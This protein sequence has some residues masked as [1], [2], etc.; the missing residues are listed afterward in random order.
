MN[1]YK[2]GTRVERTT[3]A[4]YDIG[5]LGTIVE[6]DTEKNR[7]RIFWDGDKRTW[8]TTAGVKETDKPANLDD[9]TP[10]QLKNLAKWTGGA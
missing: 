5:R 8:L 3:G 1:N 10:N 7:Y 4:Y 9:F 6:I 2:I